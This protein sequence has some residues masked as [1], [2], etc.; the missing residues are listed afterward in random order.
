MLK[1]LKKNRNREKKNERKR[2]I[3]ES[4]DIRI[5]RYKATSNVGKEL[6]MFD[7]DCV[8]GDMPLDGITD[9]FESLNWIKTETVDLP[10]YGN[11]DWLTCSPER[12]PEA[13]REA[14]PIFHAAA[15]DHFWCIVILVTQS[16]IFLGILIVADF[17][18]TYS[19]KTFKRNQLNKESVP[20]LA[21]RNIDQ[22]YPL[23]RKRINF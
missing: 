12:V 17:R 2:L 18:N 4:F 7:T 21:T 20:V 6:N 3:N 8:N 5:A 16:V 14:Q 15:H 19:F 10:E 22:Y 11:V 9:I 1:N 23:V 13:G